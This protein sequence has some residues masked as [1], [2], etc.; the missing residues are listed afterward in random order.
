VSRSVHFLCSIAVALGGCGN[1][2]AT[3]SGDAAAADGATD[4]VIDGSPIDPGTCDGQLD[5]VGSDAPSIS[6][7]VSSTVVGAPV[8][9]QFAGLSIEK[10][11]LPRAFFQAD[12]VQTAPLFQLLGHSVVRVGGASCDWES[13]W[14]PNGPGKIVG[15]VAKPDVDALAA[16][17]A[18]TGWSAIY[19]LAL[20]ASS[21]SLA[22]D[23][24]T[25]VAT[26][27]GDHL[28]AFELGNEP[29]NYPK[30]DPAHYGGTLWGP[31]KYG[32]R[33]ASF[34]HA[35]RSAV[36]QA[37]LT[38]ADLSQ[39]SLDA[40]WL[41]SVF[42]ATPKPDL[43]TQH[44]YASEDDTVGSIASLL[45]DIPNSKLGSIDQ[46]VAGAH[47]AYRMSETSTFWNG[48]VPGVS[49]TFASALWAIDYLFAIATQGGT[50]ADFHSVIINPNSVLA[51]DNGVIESVRPIYS[52][53]LLF[54]MAGTGRVVNTTQ[55]TGGLDISA[56]ALRRDDGSLSVFIVN[57]SSRGIDFHIDVGRAVSS[58]CLRKLSAP[59]LA[60]Q[61]GVAIQGAEVGSDGAFSPAHGAAAFAAGTAVA[62]TLSATSA[63]LI[64]IP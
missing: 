34:A 52:G 22:A 59:S 9:T 27:L 63:A 3:T 2:T 30:G 7:N 5:N 55:S 37:K 14:T 20:N 33:W 58:A 40:Q 51:Y 1:G 60:A 47:L 45:G 13:T 17:L 39:L 46:M 35:V 24:A 48:G 38:A 49:D 4:G 62:G 6:I 61:S 50:G 26:K 32:A 43:I 57:K 11:Y 28:L 53:L 36:P 25:Y 29:D 64:T 16:F 23:E 21:A 42:G 10:G 56:H 44:Y 15:Q 19:C 12:Q 41:P 54:T 8:T 18:Q 31:N